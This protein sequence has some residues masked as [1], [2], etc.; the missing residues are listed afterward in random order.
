MKK[1]NLNGCVVWRGKSRFDGRPIVMIVTGLTRG[2]ANGKTGDMLQTWILLDDGDVSPIQARA[3]GADASICGDCELRRLCAK[4]NDKAR[5]LCYVNVG[6]APSQVYACY[7]DGRYY[8]LS[9]YPDKSKFAGKFL[10]MG[11]YGDPAMVD[12]EIWETLIGLCGD[13]GR[14]GYTHGWR[15]ADRRLS[16][17]CMA[18]VSTIEDAELANSMGWRTFRVRKPGEYGINRANEITCPASN[19][20]GYRRNCNNCAACGGG[21]VSRRSI[22]INAHGGFAVM[23]NWTKFACGALQSV[24]AERSAS[25][26]V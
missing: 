24:I 7:R 17:L 4:G 23:G 22:A 15:W 2:S 21:D 26:E 13:N 11:S 18:S 14:T 20:A 16:R 8:D 1:M 12:F 9:D 6:Q 3:S 25:F 10:R 5:T 19:E